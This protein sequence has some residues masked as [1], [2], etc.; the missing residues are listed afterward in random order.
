MT[1][2]NAI[3]EGLVYNLTISC[4]EINRCASLI[5]IQHTPQTLKI[6]FAMNCASHVS[7]STLSPF[8]LTTQSAEVNV[9]PITSPS[10]SMS[11]SIS[12]LTA[13]AVEVQTQV[14][15]LFSIAAGYKIFA[16]S[17]LAEKTLKTISDV[18]T[19]GTKAAVSPTATTQTQTYLVSPAVSVRDRNQDNGFLDDPRKKAAIA[20]TSGVIIGAVLAVGAS[21]LS[22][23][24]KLCTCLPVVVR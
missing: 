18:I 1:S 15:T 6:K 5:G 9:C 13:H 3:R 12:K 14:K 23:R 24:L 20:T 7:T 2:V 8:R 19:F 16:T 17:P 11:N 4:K 22:R 21:I 10:V